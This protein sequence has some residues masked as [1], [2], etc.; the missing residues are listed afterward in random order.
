ME[1]LPTPTGSFA[2][3]ST[4]EDL[5]FVLKRSCDRAVHLTKELKNDSK[6][7]HITK[8][9]QWRKFAEHEIHELRDLLRHSQLSSSLTNRAN[10][11]LYALDRSQSGS[12][13]HGRSWLQRLE[14]IELHSKVVM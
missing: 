7:N 9:S 8:R 2:S 4:E 11:Y 6:R 13:L 10:Y 12:A 1:P 14:K 3:I 5:E